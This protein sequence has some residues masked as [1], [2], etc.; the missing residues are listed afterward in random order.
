[1]TINEPASAAADAGF[2]ISAFAGLGFRSEAVKTLES[3]MADLKTRRQFIQASGLA[4]VGV[5]ASISAAEDPAGEETK[6]N[7]ARE[8]RL[9]M[10]RGDWTG[11]TV[12]KVPDCVQCNLVV[13]S[14]DL[15]YEFLLYCQ[16]N[17]KP[18]PVIEVT[19]AGNPE[20]RLSAKGADLRT[21]LP[22]YRI[23]RKG[24]L[25][26]EVPQIKDFWRDDSVAF[27]IGSS[28]TFDQALVRAGVPRSPDV[29][30]LNTAIETV[31]AGRFRSKMV[32]TM[33][34]MTPAQAVIA[35]QLTARFP[36]NHGAPIHLGDPAEIGADLRHP[37]FGKPVDRIPDG[38]MPVFWACGVT[39]QKAAEE[40]K[41]DLMITHAPGH[42]FITGLQA[43]QICLP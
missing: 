26:S 7:P 33:R 4:G 32:V 3:T 39:P 40:A 13:L 19:D 42:G 27:L 11:P 31:A 12:Y 41:P 2:S 37:I 9:A 14:S 25:D 28:L 35:T 20:P 18:C 10:R 8:A 29:W 34:W 23:Y 17:P 5:A 15:A 22:K 16:R 38:V 6:E 24:V 30:V 21:D 43:D 36:A 1:L